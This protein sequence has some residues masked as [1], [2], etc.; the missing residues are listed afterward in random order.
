MATQ[1]KT[2]EVA[3]YWQRALAW[4]STLKTAGMLSRSFLTVLK[5]TILLFS[6]ILILPAIYAYS[7]DIP[8]TRYLY[9]L[10]PLFSI[11]SLY[12]IKKICKGRNYKLIFSFILSGIV[13]LSIGWM[14]YKSMDVE[15]E[16]EA[17]MLSFKIKEITKGVNEFYPEST[18]L[19]FVNVD[20]KFP[21]LKNE[22]N[23]Q[24]KIFPLPNYEKI[25][26]LLSN[27]RNN[28]LT[29]I[30]TD[31]SQNPKSQRNEFLVEIFENEYEYE[32]LKK[33]YDSKKDGFRY[34]LKIFEIDYEIFD[35][36]KKTNEK[37]LN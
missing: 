2:V 6:A 11:I 24:H 23:D 5:S 13:I 35:Q 37:I 19:K 36:H 18:Y 1:S 4:M 29:H 3:F 30:I 22:I 16:K 32:F 20:K 15:Y 28:G 12:L 34:H 9:I 33:I 7:R 10:F 31:K 26:D 17:F 8:E 21:K 14:E 27:E 25:D